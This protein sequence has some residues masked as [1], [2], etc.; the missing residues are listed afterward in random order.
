MINVSIS[1]EK[2][3]VFDCL[4]PN[5]DDKDIRQAI[6]F[7]LEENVPYK[8]DEVSYE[9]DVIK[10]PKNS[11]GEI[12][13]S[14][15]VIPKKITESYAEALTSAGLFPISFEPESKMMMRSVIKSNRN[16]LILTINDSSTIFSIVSNKM[17]RLT[18]VVPIGA[19][20]IK[21]NLIKIDGSISPDGKISEKI[22]NTKTSYEDESFAS[23][24]NVYSIWKDEIEKFIVYLQ[25]KSN[26]S[27][28]LPDTISKI[29]LAGRSAALPGLANYIMQN[30]DIEVELANV[31]SNAFDL[32]TNIP[33]LKF[34][35]SLDY[36]TAIGLA[37]S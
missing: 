26:A 6:E 4:I 21:N 10:K 28:M 37:L 22:F 36:A 34:T 8:A 33:S 18:A 7:K 12:L 11:D 2:S 15:S 25:S 35:D 30:L 31:W 5:V 29:I 16:V 14:V 27:N 20:T 19:N 13:A 23:F 17:V 3:Y 32:D 1:E 9:Y 24:L